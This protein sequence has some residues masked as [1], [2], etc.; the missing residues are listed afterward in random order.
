MLKVDGLVRQ[1]L[2]II[3]A[4]EIEFP[5]D[6]LVTITKVKT[7]PDLSQSKVYISVMPTDKQEDA[8]RILIRDSQNL[9]HRLNDKLFLKKIPKLKFFIDSSEDEARDIEDIIDNLQY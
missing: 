2:G 6:C 5:R 3:I 8:L 1:Q 4:E 7:S 9:H